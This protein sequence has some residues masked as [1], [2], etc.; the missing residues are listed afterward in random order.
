MDLDVI[1]RGEPRF[2]VRR[3]LYFLYPG[4]EIRL[5]RRSL[6]RQN[7]T[8]M[9]TKCQHIYESK[10]ILS[11]FRPTVPMLRNRYGIPLVP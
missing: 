2:H 4:I 7:A 9:G 1:P 6:D 5:P 8:V 11:D 3:L 10:K